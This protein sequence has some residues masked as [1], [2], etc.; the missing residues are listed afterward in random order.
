MSDLT[1]NL[2]KARQ[3]VAA[4]GLFAPK[5]GRPPRNRLFNTDGPEAA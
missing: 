2:A 5:K 4:K 1:R 3:S